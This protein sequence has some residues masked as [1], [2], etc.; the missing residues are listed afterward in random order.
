MPP[1]SKSLPGAGEVRE[2]FNRVAGCYDQYSALEQEVGSRLMERFQF[3]KHAP[4]RILDLGSGTGH[5]AW[6][7]KKRFRKAQVIALDASLAMSRLSQKRSSLLRPVHALS[8]DFEQLPIADRSVD[9]VFSNL[10]MQWTAEFSSLANGLR[11][12][13]RPGA[14]V[15]FSTL[16]PDS[17]KEFRQAAGYSGESGLSRRFSDMHELGDA[18]LA[19]GFTEPVMDSEFITLAYR[20]F[21]SL[22]AELE[23]TGAATHFGDWSEQTASGAGL[24]ERYRNF[25][26]EDRFPVTWEIVYGS[27]FGPEEGRPIKTPEGDVAAFSVDHL[28][29]SGKR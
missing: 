28:R 6:Q 18:L 20:D 27:A 17:M 9:L 10:A 4:R 16:G 15:L 5:W 26:R 8:A 21:A 25:L 19:A 12:V 29:Q 2:L 11:R 13:V 7:L 23:S 1:V 22:L 14:L 24:V 3:Q